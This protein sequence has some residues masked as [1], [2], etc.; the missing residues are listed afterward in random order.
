MQQQET[1]EK[2][3]GILDRLPKLGKTSQFVLIIGIVVVILGGLFMLDRNLSTKHTQL[4]RTLTN[5]Q[6]ILSTSQTPQDKF[7]ADLAQTI[8]DSEAAK[9]AFP[10]SSQAPEIMDIMLGLADDNDINVTSTAISSTTNKGDIGPTFT[11]VLGLKG[12]IPKFEN[13]LLGLDSK[14]PSAKINSVT[15]TVSTV[16][17]EYD[18]GNIKIDV[19]TYAGD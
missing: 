15:F 1:T 17:G 11:F 12:Q 14:L 2:K 9:A 7:E 19:L 16:E 5:L 3:P 6:K 8:T 4:S 10:D 13:F 18:T